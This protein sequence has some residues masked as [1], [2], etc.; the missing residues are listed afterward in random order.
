MRREAGLD[1]DEEQQVVALSEG[2]GGVG[3]PSSA[4]VSARVRKVIVVRS[5]RW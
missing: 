2:R 1:G 5:G 3:L 4:S